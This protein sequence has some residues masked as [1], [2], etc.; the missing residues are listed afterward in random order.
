MVLKNNYQFDE[1]GRY[2]QVKFKFILLK[3]IKI[4]YLTDIKLQ[5]PKESTFDEIMTYIKTLPLNDEPNLFGLDK[6]ANISCSQAESYTILETLLSLQPRD[7]G[8]AGASLE[9]V[10]SKMA[11]D[12]LSTLPGL[13]D[14]AE[15]QRE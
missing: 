10:T 9:E 2:K 7:V 4:Y 13:F 14:L 8:S 11:K 15:I 6:N 5:L 12:I 3:V 1:E